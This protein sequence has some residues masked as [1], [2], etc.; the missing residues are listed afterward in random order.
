M[1]SSMRQ[2]PDLSHLR[3][4]NGPR[5]ALSVIVA[6]QYDAAASITRA[7]PPGMEGS[8]NGRFLAFLTP[9]RPLAVATRR[10]FAGSMGIDDGGPR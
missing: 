4:V 7:G 10:P 9:G 2:L 3:R 6:R 1:Q 5:R 8:G